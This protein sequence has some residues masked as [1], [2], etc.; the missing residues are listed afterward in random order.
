VVVGGGD[1]DVSEGEG[2]AGTRREGETGG[3]GVVEDEE[4][5]GRMMIQIISSIIFE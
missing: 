3:C 4:L 5:E 1:D 2:A